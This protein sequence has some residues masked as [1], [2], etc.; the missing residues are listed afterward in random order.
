MRAVAK[1]TGGPWSPNKPA[2]TN[3]NTP[4][5]TNTNTPAKYKLKLLQKREQWDGRH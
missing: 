4:A 5:N 2:N 1:R 3:T